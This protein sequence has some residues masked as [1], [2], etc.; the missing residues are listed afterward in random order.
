ML[1]FLRKIN[2]MASVHLRLRALAGL[3]LEWNESDDGYCHRCGADV[4]SRQRLL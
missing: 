4:A 1:L 3:G 2:Q